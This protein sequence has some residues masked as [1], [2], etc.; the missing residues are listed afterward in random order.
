MIIQ[1]TGVSHT[2]KPTSHFTKKGLVFC[3]SGMESSQKIRA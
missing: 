2:G 1:I 3:Q